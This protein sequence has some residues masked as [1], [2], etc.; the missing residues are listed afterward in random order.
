MPRQL[1][2]YRAAL[3]EGGNA[4]TM[5][6]WI[7]ETEAEKARYEIVSEARQATYV[8]NG[9]RSDYGIHSVRWWSAK[10]RVTAAVRLETCSRR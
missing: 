5:V 6:A 9:H 3:D 8:H 4:K 7:A 1:V 10:A 2:Q